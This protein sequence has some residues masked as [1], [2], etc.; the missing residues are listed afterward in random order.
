MFDNQIT[1]RLRAVLDEVCKSVS[2]YDTGAR[3]HVAAKMLEAAAS[4]ETSVE[5]LRQVGCEALRVARRSP[6]P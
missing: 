2:C 5:S 6:P 4:G 1:A 3:A